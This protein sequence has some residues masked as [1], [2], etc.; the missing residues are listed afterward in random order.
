MFKNAVL[1]APLSFE[2]VIRQLRL[3]RW[4]LT[5]LNLYLQ[6][7][8]IEFVIEYSNVHMETNILQ[9]CTRKKLLKMFGGDLEQSTAKIVLSLLNDICDGFDKCCSLIKRVM[10]SI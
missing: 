9:I 6:G 7:I 1:N 2:R 4:V 10:Y 5:F 8:S 3:C